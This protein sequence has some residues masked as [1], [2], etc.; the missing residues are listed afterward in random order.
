MSGCRTLMHSPAATPASIALPPRSRMRTAAIVASAWPGRRHVPAADHRRAIR[1]RWWIAR[2]L[3]LLRDRHPHVWRR[4]GRSATIPTHAADYPRGAPCRH[5]FLEWTRILED[6]RLW[7][8]VH[9]RLNNAISEL[10]GYQVS[11]NFTVHIEE[12]VY[13]ASMDEIRDQRIAPDVFVVQRESRPSKGNAATLISP[14]TKVIPLYDPE[15]HDRYIEIRDGLSQQVVA[16]LELLSPANKA[17][18]TRGREQFLRKRQ[19]ILASATHW[20]EIDLLRAGERPREAAGRGDYC[21]LVARADRTEGYDVWDANL[22][23]PL[24]TIA[25]PLRPPYDDV[26]LDLQAALTLVYERG[27]FR[28]Q[29]RLFPASS[30]PPLLPADANWVAA[31]I[32]EWQQAHATHESG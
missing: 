30:V 26:P 18:S 25:I 6:P 17:S 21:A 9:S 10:I 5:L 1:Q 13:I 24:P 27:D 4:V 28:G 15:I 32:H 11:P 16:I 2:H 22:R 12:R 3:D 20:I 14:S 8:D 19:A 23:D 31:R 7:P 29:A